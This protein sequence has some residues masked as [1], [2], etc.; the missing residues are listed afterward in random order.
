LS[1]L[2][3]R[4]LH[5]SFGGIAAVAG[6]GFAVGEGEAVAVIGPNGAGKTTC[7][8]L[9]G[10]QLRPDAGSIRLAGREIAGS[11]PH[12]L[13]RLGIGRTFQVAAAFRS[14]TAREHVQLAILARRRKLMAAWTP[15][16]ARHRDEAERLLE[17]VGLAAEAE[18][19]AGELSYADLKRLELATVLAGEPRL[20]LADEPT[21]GIAS[22]E[23][24]QLIA[25]LLAIV[26]E[27]GIGLLFTEHDMDVVFG[28]AD[29]V[30]V[31][32]RGRIAAAGTPESVRDDPLVRDIYLGASMTEGP[33]ERA[34]C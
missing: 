13:F 5:K 10:G 2:A 26:S 34:E 28:H 19:A 27:R 1:L 18:R 23:R 11:S 17:R 14:M 15:V 31:L 7:F 9:I 16:A 4:N 21:A 29:R 12:R 8:H 25:L 20:L 24:H 3:V 6:I 30:I 32:H 33:A 22:A